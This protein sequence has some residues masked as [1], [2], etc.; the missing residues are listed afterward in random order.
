MLNNLA[1]KVKL[2]EVGPRDGLQAIRHKILL[3]QTK[4]IYISKI[5][6]SGI[7]NIEVGSFVSDRVVQMRNTP[8]VLNLITK[9]NDIRKIVLIPD[10]HFAKEAIMNN[11][12]E[13]AVFTSVSNLF[14]IKNN[15]CNKE[16]NLQKIKEILDFSKKNYIPVRG[17]ISCVFGCQLEGYR[18]NY[19]QMTASLAKT[20][21]DFGCYEI[22]LAD[23]IGVATPQMIEN[24]LNEVTKF[25]PINN[26]AI[27]LHDPHGKAPENLI[28]ALNFGI[29]VVDCATGGI[30]GCPIMKDPGMNIST[31]KVINILNRMNIVHDYDIK[32]IIDAAKFIK[33]EL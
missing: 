29:N 20:L 9:R 15:N 4:A 3:P 23:T 30:G 24:T 32:K 8:Y 26:L 14:C 19:V 17:Y 31:E 13:F 7:K 6:D 12:N 22:S 2:V 25:V 11:V 10:I 21:F 27:H 18:S 1:R 33:E 5:I 16:E 28:C